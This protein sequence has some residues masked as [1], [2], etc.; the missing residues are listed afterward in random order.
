[1]LGAG[2]RFGPSDG[3]G[4]GRWGAGRFGCW[5]GERRLGLQARAPGVGVPVLGGAGLGR[6]RRR[7]SVQASQ[8]SGR[9]LVQPAGRLGPGSQVPAGSSR[10]RWI[11]RRES[12][13]VLGGVGLGRLRYGASVR[14][15]G[16]HG[17][18]SSCRTVRDQG[19]SASGRPV[20]PS[21]GSGRGAG[22]GFGRR[23]RPRTAQ[24]TGR[25]EPNLRP[26]RF[27]FGCRLRS[28]DGSYP[29]PK[30]WTAR[31]RTVRPRA[32][33]ASRGPTQAAHPPR[34]AHPHGCRFPLRSQ[35]P[36]ARTQGD[37]T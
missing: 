13:L 20:R 32:P 6:S 25:H 1:M 4:R 29:D 3:S 11:G 18:N 22:S 17:P 28:S 30:P 9:T 37:R 24:I 36:H 15:T 27:S 35:A 19:R 23:F 33:R 16:Q 12:V 34:A 10:G 31:P 14:A 5:G 8:G 21:A 7:A 26:G 2:R